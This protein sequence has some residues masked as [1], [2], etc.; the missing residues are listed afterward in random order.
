MLSRK[1]CI[2]TFWHLNDYL[3]SLYIPNC[4]N[5]LPLV[6]ATQKCEKPFFKVLFQDVFSEFK[7]KRTVSQITISKL[8][9]LNCFKE[10]IK[11]KPFSKKI[12]PFNFMLIDS[13]KNGRE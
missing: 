12:R 7:D 2:F 8:S 13:E 4:E 5:N 1:N 3:F 6:F 9:I 10:M 11:T